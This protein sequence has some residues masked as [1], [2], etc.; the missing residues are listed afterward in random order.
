MTEDKKRKPRR[1]KADIAD[2]IH[3]AAED[4]IRHVGF[5][6]IKV[7]DIIKHAKIEPAVFY[8]RYDNLE[9][10]LSEFVKNYDYWHENIF[11]GVN[12]SYTSAEGL[13]LLLR[14][15][16]HMLNN[17]TVML[18][19]IRWEVADGNSTTL[20]TATLREVHIMPVVKEFEKLFQCSDID[21][22]ALATLVS[23]GLYYLSLHKDRSPFCGIDI[24]TAEGYER[25][26]RAIEFL[27]RKIY[28]EGDIQD[29][30]EA[31]ARR[32]REAGVD[33]EVIKRSVWG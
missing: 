26:E 4:Q 30:K 2:S 32:L 17:N 11:K 7:S 15:I 21:I 28:E 18:E 19:L 31:I 10:F 27:V 29:E 22:T 24:N 14:R 6:N 5:T 33:E 16:L 23:G 8:N 13:T 25:I 12:I 1:T 3:Q 20:R 9:E